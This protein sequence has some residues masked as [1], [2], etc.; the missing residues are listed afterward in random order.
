MIVWVSYCLFVF[1]TE[2]KLCH[3]INYVLVLKGTVLFKKTLKKPGFLHFFNILILAAL[4]ILWDMKQIE[5]SN[6]QLT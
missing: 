4:K 3:N 1:D 5:T 6:T 2:L